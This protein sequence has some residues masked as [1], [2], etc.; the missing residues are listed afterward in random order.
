MVERRKREHLEQ[1]D[2]A[3]AGYRGET[4]LSAECLCEDGVGSLSPSGQKEPL[5]AWVGKSLHK[6]GVFQLVILVTVDR[7]N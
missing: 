2:R 5:E 7:G 4:N 6:T 1:N 3:H